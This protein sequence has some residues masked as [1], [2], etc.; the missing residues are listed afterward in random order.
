MFRSTRLTEP[1]TTNNTRAGDNLAPALVLVGAA[2]SSPVRAK[3]KL[4]AV[5]P[6]SSVIENKAGKR[7]KITSLIEH[8]TIPALEVIRNHSPPRLSRSSSPAEAINK[9][10]ISSVLS[11]KDL[12][13]LYLN[14]IK[15]YIDPLI[16]KGVPLTVEEL[17]IIIDDLAGALGVKQSEADALKSSLPNKSKDYV[18]LVIAT[19]IA[20][21]AMRKGNGGY[22]NIYLPR[23]M[24]LGVPSNYALA[25]L[26]KILP[27]QIGLFY[28]SRTSIGSGNYSWMSGKIEELRGKG[29]KGAA[30]FSAFAKAIKDHMNDSSSF[31]S[32]VEGMIKDLEGLGYFGHEQVRFID[33]GF[34]TFPLFL[35]ALYKMHKPDIKTAGLVINSAVLDILPQLDKAQWEDAIRK[36]LEENPALSGYLNPGT[37]LGIMESAGTEFAHPFEHQNGAM[38]PTSA[39]EQLK[40]FVDQILFANAAIIYRRI[41]EGI[42]DDLE[43]AG[44]AKDEADT[45]AKEAMDI[46][47]PIIAEDTFS[48]KEEEAKEDGREDVQ[49]YVMPVATKTEEKPEEEIASNIPVIVEQHLKKKAPEFKLSSQTR[50]DLEGLTEAK[51]DF[52]KSAVREYNSKKA[53]D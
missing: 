1:T 46:A 49:L 27:P 17:G 4:A 11:Q 45:L 12:Q 50:G 33:T 31:K 37:L 10:A 39:R 9:L 14:I 36:Y 3:I 2:A 19:F 34:K 25:S 20:E 7:S 18:A 16:E 41:L 6:S 30:F 51:S 21:Q 38:H 42:S 53:Q 28:M 52:N 29:L 5:L 15:K 40:S 35:R 23:D 47:V 24:A 13:N 32:L 43:K 48:G 26:L 22:F 8:N 44:V